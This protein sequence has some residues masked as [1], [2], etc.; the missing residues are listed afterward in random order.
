MMPNYGKWKS[1]SLGLPGVRNPDN[2]ARTT[3]CSTNLQQQI[4]TLNPSC[5]HGGKEMK[6]PELTNP[7][8]L[9]LE[10]TDEDYALVCNVWRRELGLDPVI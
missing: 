5:Q 2:L 3:Q 9:L 8:R 6:H 7:P 4:S 1:K 10:Y